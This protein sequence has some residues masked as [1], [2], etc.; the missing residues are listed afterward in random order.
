MTNFKEKK[1]LFGPKKQAGSELKKKK[2]FF[3]PKFGKQLCIRA[4]IYQFSKKKQAGAEFKHK[5]RDFLG[6]KL[7]KKLGIRS[8]N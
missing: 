6:Q 3:G 7:E 1:G 5:R 8:R 4:K 2:R